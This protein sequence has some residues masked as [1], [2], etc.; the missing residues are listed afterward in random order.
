MFICDKVVCVPL[1]ST[2]HISHLKSFRNN[3][4]D[5]HVLYKW[6]QTFYQDCIY[7]VSQLC[8]GVLCSKLNWYHLWSKG[9]ELYFKQVK[10]YN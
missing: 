4:H 3:S 8:L 5:I 9:D 10:C 2:C 1:M 6:M 7:L